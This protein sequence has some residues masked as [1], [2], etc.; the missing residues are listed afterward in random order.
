MT[1]IADPT[2]DETLV[3]DATLTI[4]VMPN[5]KEVTLWE[6]QQTAGRQPLSS[7]ESSRALELCRDGCRTMHKFMKQSLIANNEA[8]Q[9]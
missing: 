7:E 6:H 8:G 1:M 2:E 3:A 4:A 5:W 9:S